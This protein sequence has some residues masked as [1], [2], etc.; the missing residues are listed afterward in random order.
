VRAIDRLADVSRGTE[1]WP[2]YPD[3][4]DLRHQIATSTPPDRARLAS[5]PDGVGPTS[6]KDVVMSKVMGSGDPLFR[7]R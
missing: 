6:K 2:T 5:P 7:R 4:T 1:I 3:A